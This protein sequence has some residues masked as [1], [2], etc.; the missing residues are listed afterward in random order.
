MLV[1]DWMTT[2][3]SPLAAPGQRLRCES[4]AV[5]SEPP[6]SGSLPNHSSSF[7][8]QSRDIILA[9]FGQIDG[10]SLVVQ[11]NVRRVADHHRKRRLTLD[12]AL[13]SRWIL[14]RENNLAIPV[15]HLH[16]GWL[17]KTEL[18]DVRNRSLNQQPAPLFVE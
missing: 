6:K 2:G 18:Q 8:R 10:I 9:A 17:R 1:I 13:A 14:L 7:N 15:T 3:A 4:F 5:A 11:G 12:V 16:P